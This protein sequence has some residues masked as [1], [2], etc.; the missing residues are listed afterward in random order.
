MTK[1]Q[2]SKQYDPEGRMKFKIQNYKFQINFN[3]QN[4][5]FKTI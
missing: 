1:I 3:D 4:P 5:K 2:N